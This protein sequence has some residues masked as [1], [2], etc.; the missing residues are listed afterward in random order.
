MCQ[1]SQIMQILINGLHERVV[2][3]LWRYCFQYVLHAIWME[4]KTRRVDDTALPTS[5]L[6]LRL[7]KQV[8]NRITSLRRKN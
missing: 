8:R 4:R 6:L 1:W 3:F 7:D 5:C 2:T